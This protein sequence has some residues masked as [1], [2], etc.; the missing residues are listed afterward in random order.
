MQTEL[1]KI[2]YM[3]QKYSLLTFQKA[4]LQLPRCIL[5][6]E[7]KLRKA[8][9]KYNYLELIFS[10]VLAFSLKCVVLLIPILETLLRDFEIQIK[11]HKVPFAMNINN[12][13]QK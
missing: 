9:Q 1:T 4:N 8:G 12:W 3:N 11:L 2:N 10:L 6:L 13:S 5:G 7:H